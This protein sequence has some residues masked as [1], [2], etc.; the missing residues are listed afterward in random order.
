MDSLTL[1]LILT[2]V[3]V[4]TASLAGRRWGPAV[5]GWLVALPFT[6]APIVFF[7]AGSYGLGFATD[8]AIGTLAGAI[9]QAAFCLIYSWLAGHWGWPRTL[10][11]SCF[12]FAAATAVLRQLILPVGLL[13]LLV[14]FVLA[15]TLRLMPSDADATPTR[16]GPPPQ[17]DIP[18]RMVVATVFVLLL[19]GSAPA[20][21]PQL[22]GL[23]AP[24]PLYGTIL[25]VFAQHLHGPRP[26]VRVLRG[27]LLGLFAF[28]SFFL[29]LATLLDRVGIILAFG[30]ASIVALVLQAGTLWMLRQ[31]SGQRIEAV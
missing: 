8:V 3:L 9:S 5:S 29:V 13:F 1:K 6:S 20:I 24:F 23:L 30:T 16:V 19:T 11:A 4:G 10:I 26:A 31:S 18:T 21:G 25:A 17:W 12:G 22:T 28:A 27:L 2:P 14:I 15:L 7:L